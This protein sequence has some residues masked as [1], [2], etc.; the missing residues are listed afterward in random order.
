MQ[1]RRTGASAA[2]VGASRCARARRRRR[3]H[4]GAE[5]HTDDRA[6]GRSATAR[7]LRVRDSGPRAYSHRRAHAIAT[8]APR[9]SSPANGISATANQANEAAT[10]T[11]GPGGFYTEPAGQPHFAF[12]GDLPTVVYITGQGP[13]D[14][15][16]VVAADAA[17][18]P[19]GHCHDFV[20]DH[21][22]SARRS[23][24]HAAERRAGDH[25]F[26]AGAGRIDPVAAEART[27]RQHHRA[28]PHRQA[29]RIADRA[30]DG[31]REDRA[32]SADH[33]P[34]HGSAARTYNHSTAPRSM[35]GKTRTSCAR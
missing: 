13:T 1:R 23:S 19:V 30:L 9:W 21:S 2:D 26:P 8:I 10:R 20:Q 18:T 28:R 12:T 29:L 25:R 7:A 33:P 6:V 5:R 31:E 4:L 24:A 35:P 16:Y 32:Q 17:F 34:D 11:L 22:R 15:A 14:T 3:G 27:G